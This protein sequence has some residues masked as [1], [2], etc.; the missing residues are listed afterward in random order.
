MKFIKRKK[1]AVGNKKVKNATEII[2]DGIKFKSKLEAYCYRR[3]KEEGFEP[4][5][6]GNKI[7]LLEGFAPE[8]NFLIYIPKMVGGKKVPIERDTRRVRAI[9]LTP[10]FMFYFAGY[11]IIVETKG[12]P[13]DAYPNKRK[14]FF[15]ILNEEAKEKKEKDFGIAFFEP[16]SQA[17]VEKTIN[18]IKEL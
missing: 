7:T 5:Y 2:L 13:N 1:T 9:T 6:Q 3:L 8:E 17:D 14:A 16:S 12:N 4:S 15:E 11:K 10:D 18:I